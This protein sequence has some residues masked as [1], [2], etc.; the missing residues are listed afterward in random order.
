MATGFSLSA[1]SSCVLQGLS[2]WDDTGRTVLDVR[3][4]EVMKT[5]GIFVVGPMVK[6]I[7]DVGQP[8]DSGEPTCGKTGE[9]VLL[10]IEATYF[11]E[12]AASVSNVMNTLQP[13][14]PPR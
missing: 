3:C 10:R 7:V 13:R 12:E 14:H 1:S 11:H 8:Q 6:H 2:D 5:K 4:D 9:S